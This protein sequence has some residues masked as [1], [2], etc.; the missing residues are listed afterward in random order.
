MPILLLANGPYFKNIPRKQFSLKWSRSTVDES[1]DGTGWDCLC[2][3][4]HNNGLLY[5]PEYVMVRADP[6]ATCSCRV[7]PHPTCSLIKPNTFDPIA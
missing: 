7:Q 4:K 1:I 5:T 3:W 2:S 6:P